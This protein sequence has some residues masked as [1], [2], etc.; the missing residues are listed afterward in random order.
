MIERLRALRAWGAEQVAQRDPMDWAAAMTLL[1]VAQHAEAVWYIRHAATA[2]A[3]LGLVLRGVPRRAWFWAALFTVFALGHARLWYSV[4]N[5]E[6]LLTYWCLAL[7]AARLAREPQRVMATTA[8]LL[9]GLCFLFATIWK[10]GLGEFRNGSFFEYASLF[11]VRFASLPLV[12]GG[13]PSSTWRANQLERRRLFTPAAPA[14]V[15]TVR[16][17]PRLRM[18]AQVMAIVT[19]AIE[20][21]IALCFLWP[22][23][24]GPSRIRDPVMLVFLVGVYPLASVVGFGWLLAA[25]GVAQAHERRTRWEVGYLAVFVL[26][27]FYHLPFGS[28]A[29]VLKKAVGL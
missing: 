13:M 8:R 14:P 11:D 9:I 28:V 26:M 2:L 21:L 16:S 1:V 19:I 15:V 23:G 18:V 10:A 20:G 5:H 22:E 12:V 29:Q 7:G 27:P 25:M 6:Y 3:A 4:D 17:L 24:R